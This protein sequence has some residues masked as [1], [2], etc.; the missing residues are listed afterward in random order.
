MDELAYVLKLCPCLQTLQVDDNNLGEEGVS[1]LSSTIKANK[2]LTSL[3]IDRTNAVGVGIVALALGLQNNEWFESFSASGNKIKDEGCRS[4]CFAMKR[5]SLLHTIDLSGNCITMRCLEELSAIFQNNPKLQKI[6]LQSNP[7]ASQLVNGVL[8]RRAAQKVIDSLSERERTS[9]IPSPAP[10]EPRNT[11]LPALGASNSSILNS[12]VGSL[13]GVGRGAGLSQSTLSTLPATATAARP[14][15]ASMMAV[16]KGSGTIF[17]EQRAATL[18][19]SAEALA[20]EEAGRELGTY[21]PLIPPKNSLESPYYP[22]FGRGKFSNATSVQTFGDVMPYTMRNSCGDV[23][24]QKWNA[25]MSTAQCL[26]LAD[27]R[28]VHKINPYSERAL[29]NNIGGLV[30]TEKRLRQAFHE[31]DLNANGYLD[32]EEFKALYNTFENF[33]VELDP[34]EVEETVKKFKLMDD[35]RL[36]FEEFAML[37]CRVAQR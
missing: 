30:I 5:M 25:D 8:S 37:M 32:A 26:F 18:V 10:L 11:G 1:V 3:N 2:S 13:R 9:L 14:S 15:A 6:S 19:A 34:R 22:G 27:P 31:L 24:V 28:R 23:P 20:A 17:S 4:L 29:E 12:S 33:G 36:S 7:I 21:P 16:S 35:G